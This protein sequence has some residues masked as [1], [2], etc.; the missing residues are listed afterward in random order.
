MCTLASGNLCKAGVPAPAASHAHGAFNIEDVHGDLLAVGG[1]QDLLY[2][3]DE[4]RVQRFK[5]SGEPVEDLSLAGLSPTGRATA[6]AV[7]PAGDVFVADRGSPGVREYDPNGI[8]QP[9]VIAPTTPSQSIVAMALDPNGKLGII[10]GE[11]TEQA[12][13]EFAALY[14]GSGT[15]ISDI[16]PPSGEMTGFPKGLAFS[17]ADDLYVAENAIQEIEAYEGVVF[18]EVLACTTGPVTATSAQLCGEVNPNVLATKGFFEYG[19]TTALGSKTP[20]LFEGSGTE[21]VLV[22]YTLTELEPNETYHYK[23]AAEAEINK[24]NL[25]VRGV[26]TEFHTT[27]L[28]PVIAGEPSASF[29]K[30]Q[31]AVLSGAVNP[32]HDNT[33]YHFEYAPC[34]KLAG[35][36][37]LLATS[38]E[39]SSQYDVIGTTQEIIGLAAATTYSYRLVAKNEAG[40]VTGPEGTFT[41]TPA[42]VVRAVTGPAN[43][44]TATSATISGAVD[45]GGQPAAYTFEL[46]I[47]QGELTRFG[48]VFSAS[49][50]T[51][52]TIESVVL[53]GLQPDTTYAYKITIHSGYGTATGVT[54]TFKTLPLPSSVITPPQPVPQLPIPNIQF[55]RES[56]VIKCRHGLTR[57]KHNKC[58][59][60]KKVSG[61]GK[62]ARHTK[63]K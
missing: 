20:V 55:P 52:P 8:L 22:Q 9:L 54:V 56:H 28:P 42:P 23:I 7:D 19:T 60:T 6:I 45:P 36:K 63:K 41:T 59:K 11:S 15:K 4:G 33:D 26:D 12:F 38:D 5:A 18:A 3:G 37:T 21:F 14:S 10:T 62:K 47:Y 32:E 31:S 39:E 34:A 43:A 44:I 17:P 24:E 27:L 53:T 51:Q 48:T 13:K 16:A 61:H 29:V 40:S 50:G 58:V 2:V 1:P 46:G 35:C 57:N 49:T 30:E 25:V